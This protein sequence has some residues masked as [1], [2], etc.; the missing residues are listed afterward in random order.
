ML[1]AQ[2]Q[3]RRISYWTRYSFPRVLPEGNDHWSK[4]KIQAIDLSI[5][6]RTNDLLNS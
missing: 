6:L 5:N 3:P 2:S 4:L 1:I